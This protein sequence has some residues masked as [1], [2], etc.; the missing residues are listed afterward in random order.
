M[1]YVRISFRNLLYVQCRSLR[2]ERVSVV[3]AWN[4]FFDAWVNL[5]VSESVCVHAVVRFKLN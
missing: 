1:R 2:R 3:Q 4:E 5:C